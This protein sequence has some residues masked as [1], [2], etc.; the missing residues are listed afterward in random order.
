MDASI[1]LVGNGAFRSLLLK[2]IQEL[3]AFTVEVAPNP[4]EAAP[5][6][7]AQQP[8]I[9]V[10]QASLPGCLELCRQ[11]KNQSRLAW[12]CCILLDDRPCPARQIQQAIAADALEA[13][14][15]GYDWI[16]LQPSNTEILSQQRLLQAHIRSGLRRV[17]NHRELMR[18]NDLLSAI[19]LSDPLTELNNRRAL[20]WELPRQIH[21]ARSQKTPISLMMLDVDFFKHVNDTYGHLVGDRVLTLLAARLR[22][23][24]RF[25]DTPFRYGGEEFVI[26]LGNTNCKGASRIAQRICRLIGDQPFEI[27]AGL[28]LQI[29]ISAGISTLLDDDDAKG[30]SLLRRADENLLQAKSQGRNRVV[31]CWNLD[32]T[33]R[34]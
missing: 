13:S 26:I 29:T 3:A 16:V 14:A 12:I 15:D 24:L 9:L 34:R 23:N 18:A 33:S 6:I 2:S 27:N 28:E 32:T 11:T 20:E 1:L 8:D 22:Y 4:D 30:I 7:Q 5:L 21:S 19:A 17:Q 31:G 25:Y 10:M